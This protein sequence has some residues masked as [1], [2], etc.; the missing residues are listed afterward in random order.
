[1]TELPDWGAVYVDISNMEKP[2]AK[3]IIL[4]GQESEIQHQSSDFAQSITEEMA[5]FM[6][7]VAKLLKEN[8]K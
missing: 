8:T 7:W 3:Y 5:V 4:E 1:M 6:G 2:L